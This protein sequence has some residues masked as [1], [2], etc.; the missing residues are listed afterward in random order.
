MSDIRYWLALNLLPDIG[1]VLSRRLLSAFGEPKNIFKMP[2]SEL[3][4]VEDIGENRAKKIIGFRDWSKVNREIKLAEKKNINIVP[5]SDKLYPEGLKHLTDAPL[6]IYVKGKL[7]DFD[8]YA[9]AIVGSRMP[10]DYGLQV[11][12]RISRR[13]ASSGLTI[14]SGMARGIDAM[15]HRGA[16][17][18]GGR[19]IAVLGSGVD[20][21]YPAENRGLMRAISSGGAV[22]S[23]FPLGTIPD[24]GN[25][26]RRNR[27]ISGL[28]LGVIVIEAAE[29][30]GS[31]IT[32]RYAIEQGRE[33]F[34]VPGNVTSG[35]SKGTNDLIKKG[36]K[37]I[38]DADEVID[39]LRH[40]I[41]GILKEDRQAV[42]SLPEMTDKEKRLYGILGNEAMHIDV[43][44][45]KLNITTPEALSILLSLELKGIVKQATGKNFLIS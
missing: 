18:A 33:V 42:K 5:L 11:A 7:K 35:V 32:A 6:V 25:F 34:A 13:L 31:L 19:T 41:K 10:T 29:D 3:R 4:K 39:E 1:P 23:E 36:A 8:K 43:I 16:L 26:P 38:E 30:S 14:V 20:V 45:R 17:S 9:V 40:Q 2:I 37:L 12:E 27:I 24:K 28:S 21:A 22:V 15:A 44:T